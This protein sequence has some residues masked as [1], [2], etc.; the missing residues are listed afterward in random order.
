MEKMV[1]WIKNGVDIN[2]FQGRGLYG[3]GNRDYQNMLY[4]IVHLHLSAKEDDVLPVVKKDG[5]AKPGKYL[6]YALFK[7]DNA[8]LVDI[9][10][11]PEPQKKGGCNAVEWTS[12]ELLRIILNNWPGLLEDNKI[13]GMSL[14][15]EKGNP[16][17]IDDQTISLLMSNHVNTFVNINNTLYLPGMGVVGSGDSLKAVFDADRMVRRVQMAQK[18]FE[19][20]SDSIS[21]MFENVLKKY[22]KQ[23]PTKF[24]IHFDYVPVLE[25][26]VIIDR[27][28][29][30]ACDDQGRKTY[31]LSE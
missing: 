25:K 20:N 16:I 13:E 28:S 10:I 23:V 9:G 21:I 14:C 11:H 4:G 8:Y 2:C 27:I 31:L 30:V 1:E 15:D 19:E 5:F 7:G 17:E 22:G 6:L 18:Y 24:D 26:F 29:G 12:K 3:E